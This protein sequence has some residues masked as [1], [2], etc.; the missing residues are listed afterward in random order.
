MSANNKIF[1]FAMDA[2]RQAVN[3]DRQGM[4]EEAFEKY[5]RAAESL[6]EFLRFNKNKKLQRI[7][8]DRMEEYLARAAYL[9]KKITGRT[10]K[11][12]SSS[13]SAGA[14]KSGTGDKSKVADNV[15][16]EEMDEDTKRLQEMIQDTVITEKPSVSWSDVA[17]LDRVKQTLRESIVLPVLHP[18]IFKGARKPWTGVL[19]FGPPGTGKTLMAKAA[20]NECTATFYSADSASLVSKW[21]GE[22]EKLIKTLFEL[23]RKKSPSLIFIDEVDS[24]TSTRGGSSSEGGGERRLKTQLMQEMQGMKSTEKERVLVLGATNR[25]WDLDPAFLRRFEKKIYIPLPD[26]ESRT[27]IYKIHSKGVD[28]APDLNFEELARLSV[29]YSGA[30]ISLVCREAIMVPLRELDIGGTIGKDTVELR[31]VERKDFLDALDVQ[32]PVSTPEDL[33]RYKEWST[34]FGV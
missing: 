7:V 5:M 8:E 9:K 4:V 30:D 26:L 15:Q 34:E 16:D 1:N 27:A 32:K 12:V 17:G 14:K 23:A 24:L 25:P 3:F 22:S 11:A 13:N 21:L 6:L 31:P 10:V 33:K 18:E 28:L 19:L 29:G 20:A 2:A